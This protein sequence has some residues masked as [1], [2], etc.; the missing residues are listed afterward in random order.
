MLSKENN[1][2]KDRKAKSTSLI[3]ILLLSLNMCV[4]ATRK[5]LASPWSPASPLPL[6]ASLSL[7]RR[8]RCFHEAHNGGPSLSFVRVQEGETPAG[9]DLRRERG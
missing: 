1:N 4:Y 2:Y 3:P 9:R 7:A 5:S 8:R 6:P